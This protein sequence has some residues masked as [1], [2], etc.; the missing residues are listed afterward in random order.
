VLA[1]QLLLVAFALAMLVQVIFISMN[2]IVQFEE[3][4]QAILIKEMIL[5]MLI[6]L[7]GIFIFVI[8][9]RRL[10]ESRDSDRQNAGNEFSRPNS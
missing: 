9:L 10:D 8:Q 6:V 1:T 5:T 2:G 3:N 4:S 7:F